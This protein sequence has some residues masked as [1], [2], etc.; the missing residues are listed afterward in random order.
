[1]KRESSTDNLGLDISI[2]Q[3]TRDAV[4]RLP[5]QVLLWTDDVLLCIPIGAILNC[6]WHHGKIQSAKLAVL[7][8][9]GGPQ[10]VWYKGHYSDLSDQRFVWRIFKRS[11]AWQTWVDKYNVSKVD[12]S[13][14][15]GLISLLR[16]RLRESE[17]RGD[18]L[19]YGRVFDL[20][21]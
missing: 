4:R 16:R 1:M 21:T 17:G 10:V 6:P 5:D 19:D 9:S 12:G 11:P 13:L 15:V 2:K 14:E 20:L 7:S 8:E 18:D 3:T